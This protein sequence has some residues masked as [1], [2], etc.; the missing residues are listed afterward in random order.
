MHLARTAATSSISNAMGSGNA[1]RGSASLAMGGS[2]S[3]GITSTGGDPGGLG[4]PMKTMKN[5]QGKIRPSLNIKENYIRSRVASPADIPSTS[6]A[7]PLDLGGF[8][9]ATK[10]Q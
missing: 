6:G 1:G 9:A 5:R 3:G 4:R 8:P 7:A 10:L 2:G